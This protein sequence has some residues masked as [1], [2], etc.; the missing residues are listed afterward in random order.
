MSGAN[1]HAQAAAGA[2]LGVELQRE[3][4]FG[5]APR[6]HGRGFEADRRR[7]GRI[8]QLVFVEE[9]SPDNRMRTGDR[10]LAALDTEVGVPDGNFIGDVA[11]FPGGGARGEGAVHRQGADRQGVAPPRHDLRGEGLYEVGRG[12]RHGGRAF[13]RARHGLWHG[14]FAEVRQGVINGRDVLGHDVRALEPVGLVDHRLDAGY[15]LIARQHA[16]DREEAGLQH[17]I[18]AATKAGRLGDLRGVDHE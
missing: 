9:A 3:A 7:I 2:V 11:L 5:V 4:A 12:R 15:R 18:D 10:A 8:G 13:K 17:R 6:V 1:L 14:D 16:G